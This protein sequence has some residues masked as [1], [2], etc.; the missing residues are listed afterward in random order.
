LAINIV[1]E[2]E[3]WEKLTA[4]DWLVL[5]SFLGMLAFLLNPRLEKNKLWKA[6][7]IPLASIIGSGYL[8]CAPLLYYILGDWAVL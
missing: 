2:V 8:V 7:V 6:T 5:F 3:I 4:V 1:V